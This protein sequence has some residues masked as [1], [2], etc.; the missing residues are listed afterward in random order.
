MTHSYKTMPSPVGVLTLVASG[1]ALAAVLWANEDPGRVRLGPRALEPGHPVLQEA[2]RQLDAYF[3]GRSRQFSVPLAFTG[4]DFQRQVWRALAAIP[5]GETLSY[6]R[7]A[8]QVGRP[9]AVRAVGAAIGRNPLAILIPCHR[10][11]GANGRLTGFA[12][13][14]EAKAWLLGREAGRATADSG[15]YTA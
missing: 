10:V 6:G 5:F 7:I 15:R 4:T 3:A 14:L 1:P 11:I 9:R 8:E 2:E 12:G 13:G